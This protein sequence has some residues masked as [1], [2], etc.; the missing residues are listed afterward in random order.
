VALPGMKAALIIISSGFILQLVTAKLVV[1]A[2][3]N[4][5]RIVPNTES[6]PPYSVLQSRSATTD[7]PLYC[8]QING[9]F[10]N[11]FFPQLK[12]TQV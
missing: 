10:F 1:T 3:K 7:T 5:V 4:N 11:D 6:A 2:G 9:E 8:P 12:K